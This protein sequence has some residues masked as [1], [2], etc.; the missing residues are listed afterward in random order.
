MEI[1]LYNI[2]HSRITCEKEKKNCCTYMYD[3]VIYTHYYIYIYM[4]VIIITLFLLRFRKSLE[5]PRYDSSQIFIG[6]WV[7]ACKRRARVRRDETRWT[8]VTNRLL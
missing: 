6:T 5:K 3:I 4:C 1:L 8:T 7:H 2:V